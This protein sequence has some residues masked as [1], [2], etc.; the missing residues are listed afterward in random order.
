MLQ[1]EAS[2]S[3]MKARRSRCVFPEVQLFNFGVYG[4]RLARTGLQGR[5]GSHCLLTCHFAGKREDKIG[6][7]KA[8]MHLP[9]KMQRMKHSSLAEGACNDDP[10]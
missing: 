7:Y 4:S 5:G 1:Y 3:R 6:L 8:A 2:P 10:M 9:V